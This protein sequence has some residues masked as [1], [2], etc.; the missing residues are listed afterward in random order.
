MVLGEIV[1]LFLCI[2]SFLSC[3]GCLYVVLFLF[4]PKS[5]TTK[6]F[7]VVVVNLYY[8]HKRLLVVLGFEHEEYKISLYSS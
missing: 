2:Q 8:G 1:H 5:S 7:G 3:R 6:C 4:N